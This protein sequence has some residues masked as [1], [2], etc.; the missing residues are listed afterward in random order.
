MGYHDTQ[1]ARAPATARSTPPVQSLREHGP[2]AGL[3]ELRLHHR[4]PFRRTGSMEASHWP[5]AELLTTARLRLEPLR[6]DHAPEMV[7]VLDD[8]A[9]FDFTG[10]TPPTE[11]DLRAR[12]R[13]Q[14]GRRVS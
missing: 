11:A 2:G 9:L 10:G 5:R 6:V 12:Y 1:A 3:L 4:S 14:A 7:A 13:R 8:P